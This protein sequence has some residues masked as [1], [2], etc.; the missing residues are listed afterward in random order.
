MTGCIAHYILHR[1]DSIQSAGLFFF[2]C[3]ILTV[4]TA[5]TERQTDVATVLWTIYKIHMVLSTEAQW[6][7]QSQNQCPTRKIFKVFSQWVTDYSLTLACFSVVNFFVGN[8]CLSQSSKIC[9]CQIDVRMKLNS[10][11]IAQNMHE[12]VVASSPGPFPAVVNGAC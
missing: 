1:N 2:P 3:R 12:F 10:L 11:Q 4:H 7:I 8:G 9:K 5:W 6:Y